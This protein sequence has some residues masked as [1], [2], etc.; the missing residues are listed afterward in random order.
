MR[1]RVLIFTLALLTGAS[2][3][4]VLAPA[5][6][7]HTGTI[8]IGCDAVTF[9]YTKVPKLGT[10]LVDSETI[11][12]DGVVVVSKSFT[13]TGAAATDTVPISIGAGPHRVNVHASWTQSGGGKIS[14][15]E[16]LTTCGIIIG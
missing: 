6:S 1:A 15:F 7:A 16:K 2:A 5:A 13:F 14:L 11:A 4:A 3:T 12:V 9:S 8:A 10:N